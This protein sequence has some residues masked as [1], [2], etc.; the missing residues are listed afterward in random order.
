VTF[1]RNPFIMKLRDVSDP[2]FK[3]KIVK[4]VRGLV[5]SRV[6]QQTRTDMTAWMTID[7]YPDSALFEGYLTVNKGVRLDR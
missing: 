2:F 7:K 1:G 5:K 6:S 4:K 3:K